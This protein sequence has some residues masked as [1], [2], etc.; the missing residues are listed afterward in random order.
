V[1]LSIE[2]VIRIADVRGET[3]LPVY[4]LGLI[5][6]SAEASI[7]HDVAFTCQLYR[8]GA[9]FPFLTIKSKRY[10]GPNDFADQRGDYRAFVN[11]LHGQVVKN[12]WPVKTQ[13][14]ARPSAL[15]YGLWSNAHW[16]VLIWIAVFLGAVLGLAALDPLWATAIPDISFALASLIA[17]AFVAW[18]IYNLRAAYGPWVYDAARVPDAVLPSPV[19]LD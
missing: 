7:A 19:L 15:M 14:A 13:I 1:T 17:A 16:A 9:R 18:R 5:E 6:L 3:H 10:R 12:A 11:A 2:G 4:E 8:K